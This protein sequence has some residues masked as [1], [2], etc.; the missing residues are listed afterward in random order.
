MSTCG[1]HLCLNVER[2]QHYPGATKK[3]QESTTQ[4]PV[5]RRKVEVPHP[6]CGAPPPWGGLQGGVQGGTHVQTQRHTHT[7]AHTHTYSHAHTCAHMHMAACRH[8]PFV[9]P[10][11][12][13]TSYVPGPGWYCLLR[14]NITKSNSLVSL[15]RTLAAGLK[16]RALP[17][18][19]DANPLRGTLL[20]PRWLLAPGH[21]RGSY[22]WLR[23]QHHTELESATHT[24]LPPRPCRLSITTTTRVPATGS[25]PFR[26]HANPP[27]PCRAHTR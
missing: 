5:I 19:D 16:I 6:P 14:L 9:L 12:A 17:C 18:V 27:P 4:P 20:F 13:P 22:T 11:S 15:P 7:Y 2:S 24:S 8:L 21:E 10:R 26:R 23:H 3:D 25:N 1:I